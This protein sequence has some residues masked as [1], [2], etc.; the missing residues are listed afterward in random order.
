VSAGP[1]GHTL[2]VDLAGVADGGRDRCS[3]R[4][5]SLV[6]GDPTRDVLIGSNPVCSEVGEIAAEV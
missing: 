6:V 3:V 5:P 2:A 1:R 4:E